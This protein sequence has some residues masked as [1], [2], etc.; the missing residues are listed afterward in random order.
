M[1]DAHDKLEWVITKTEDA[2]TKTITIAETNQAKLSVIQAKLDMME[3]EYEAL[4]PGAGKDTFEF[5]KSE[6][7]EINDDF[8]EIMLAQEFQDLTGQI[9]RKVIKLVRDLEGQLVKLVL[10]FGVKV[11]P[12]L[13]QKGDT[14]GPQ[15]RESEEAFADQEDVDAMLADFGF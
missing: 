3:E 9:L 13:K 2:A 10:M 5:V 7:S 1:P 11:E 12:Q 14:A 4:V 15:I 8:L 6:L